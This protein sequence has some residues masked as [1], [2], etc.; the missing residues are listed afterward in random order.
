MAAASRLTLSSEGSGKSKQSKKHSELPLRCFALS[1]WL[2]DDAEAR[3][4]LLPALPIIA[5]PHKRTTL[6]LHPP[7]NPPQPPLHHHN[8]TTML[9]RLALNLRPTFLTSASTAARAFSSTMPTVHQ[10]TVRAFDSRRVRV[11]VSG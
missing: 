8:I 1:V 3:V 5:Y 4:L 10:G 6:N 7:Y 11:L 2:A 9:S